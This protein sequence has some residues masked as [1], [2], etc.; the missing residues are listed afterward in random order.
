MSE[1]Q[2]LIEINMLQE[3]ANK[4]TDPKEKKSLIDDID[5]YKRQLEG[6]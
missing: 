6:Y 2:V 5:F 3:K 4:T 1:G